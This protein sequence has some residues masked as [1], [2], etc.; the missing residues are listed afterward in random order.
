[1]RLE[2]AFL[3]A[4]PWSCHRHVY[5]SAP[6]TLAMASLLAKSL[7]TSVNSR[8]FKIHLPIHRNANHRSIPASNSLELPMSHVYCSRPVTR[9][10]AS[11]RGKSFPAI[12]NSPMTIPHIPIE[13][14]VAGFDPSCSARA[15]CASK[16]AASLPHCSLPTGS[17]LISLFTDH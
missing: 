3:Q 11:D 17:F 8:S 9:A 16:L 7:P 2:G 13:A 6:V 1:M 4:T 10:T 12:A 15:L 14:R 5:L